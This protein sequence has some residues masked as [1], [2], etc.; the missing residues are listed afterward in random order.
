MHAAEA[1]GEVHVRAC[2]QPPAFAQTHGTTMGA[3]HQLLPPQAHLE[4]LGQ[5]RPVTKATLFLAFPA[6]SCPPAAGQAGRER[7]ERFLGRRGA[8]VKF[9]LAAQ[10]FAG[11]RWR[12]TLLAIGCSAHNLPVKACTSYP[13]V[14]TSFAPPEQILG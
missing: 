9:V 3:K 12:H 5:G 8:S 7:A 10:L 1:P 13:A 2:K 11:I 6:A 14:P 4:A